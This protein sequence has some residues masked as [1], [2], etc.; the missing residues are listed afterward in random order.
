MEHNNNSN[1]IDE[2]SKASKNKTIIAA[3]LFA[4]LTNSWCTVN[5]I[6]PDWHYTT[7]NQNNQSFQTV[8]SETN[9]WDNFWENEKQRA[10]NDLRNAKTYEER[11]KIL[12]YIQLIDL[13]ISQWNN[14]IS[15]NQWQRVR[16]ERWE[17]IPQQVHFEIIGWE[18]R[19][20]RLSWNLL[21]SSTWWTKTENRQLDRSNQN[22]WRIWI[23]ENSFWNLNFW[24][25]RRYVRRDIKINY[26]WHSIIVEFDRQT[27]SIPIL[28]RNNWRVIRV[29]FE[30]WYLD[31]KNSWRR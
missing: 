1:I 4:V 24:D 22:I 8:R 13:N 25:W 20:T 12:E 27:R 2:K 21:K 6:K 30:N 14:L 26:D 31:I 3:W 16:I 17:S 29:N 15:S 18:Y 19:Y 11:R 9:T 10:T 28:E 23:N 5:V 7:P